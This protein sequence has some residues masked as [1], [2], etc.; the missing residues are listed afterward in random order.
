VGSPFVTDEDGAFVALMVSE[1]VGLFVGGTSLFVSAEVGVLD[2]L[3]ESEWVGSVVGSPFVS[4]EVGA[5]VGF[6]GEED[7]DLLSEEDGDKDGEED[8]NEVG[9]NVSE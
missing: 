5:F 3:V 1:W 4:A 7:G 6:E 9:L 2:G 8:G